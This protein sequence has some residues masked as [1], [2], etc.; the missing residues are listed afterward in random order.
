[1]TGGRRVA[2]GV[3]RPL[4]AAGRRGSLRRAA[5]LCAATSLLVSSA[6]SSDDQDSPA[7]NDSSDE[8]VAREQGIRP[9]ERD[10][11]VGEPSSSPPPVER[12]T[13]PPG[14][15]NCRSATGVVL[16]VERVDPDGD[17]DAH[18]VLASRQS[19]T[20]PGISVIDVKRSLR[21]SPLPGRGDRLSAA[22]PVYRG[23]YG[24]RQIE[25]IELNVARRR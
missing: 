9:A 21:P 15:G 2:A 7:R 16:Y 13:C 14:A 23:S 20:A 8:Q 17:G 12:A 1:V 19:I 6:C 22:G 18:F 3:A 4:G 24:Q 5:A 11:S 25:A 10:P